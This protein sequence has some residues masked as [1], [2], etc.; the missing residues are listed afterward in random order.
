MARVLF[1]FSAPDVVAQW[2]AIDDRV[3]GGVSQS[4]LRHDA[5][6]FAVFEGVVSLEQN[7]GFASVRSRPGAFGAPGASAYVLE[8]AG[9]G[10]RYKLSLRVDDRFDGITWQ[11]DFAPLAA[12]WDRVRLSLTEFRPT[13]RGRAVADAPALDPANVRQVGLLIAD[14][15]AGPFELAVRAIGAE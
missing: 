13:F 6:G 15:Q 14:R 11:A 2:S 3:M 12:R 4:R 9:D 1:D 10:R 7:G 5:A 8:A